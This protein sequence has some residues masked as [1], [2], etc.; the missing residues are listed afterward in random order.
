[1]ADKSEDKTFFLGIDLGT[2]SV[3]VTLI[4]SVSKNVVMSHKEDAK[5]GVIS[6]QSLLHQRSEQN[7]ILILTALHT[8]LSH[9]PKELMS[10]VHNLGIC[11]QMHGCVFWKSDHEKFNLQHFN[12][13][14]NGEFCDFISHL[15]TWEDQRCTTEFISSLPASKTSIPL[16]TG[17]GCATIFWF[18]RNSPCFLSSYDCAG[19]V[20][21]LLVALLCG[22]SKPVM[23]TQNAVSWGCY[24]TNQ[25]TWEKEM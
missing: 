5:A 14:Y 7:V 15:I 19:T 11:G 21:D 9:F 16:S 8:A 1:M 13:R 17:F 20:Q 10:R 2:T 6:D 4:D 22:L 12:E 23:S 18:A 24:D 25:K 3:K